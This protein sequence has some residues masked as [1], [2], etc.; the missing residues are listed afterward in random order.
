MSKVLRQASQLVQ[1]ESEVLDDFHA[2]SHMFGG[3]PGSNVFEH[4]L[5]DAL[6]HRG[7][8][9]ERFRAEWKERERR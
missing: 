4:V 2:Y 7:L 3:E 8:T 6:R 9:L 1:W 5:V